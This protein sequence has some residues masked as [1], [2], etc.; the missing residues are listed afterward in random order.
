MSLQ[1]DSEMLVN[2]ADNVF[3][4]FLDFYF[5][6]GDL[7]GPQP[8]IKEPCAAYELQVEHHGCRI[9]CHASPLVMRTVFTATTQCGRACSQEHNQWCAGGFLWHYHLNHCGV[10]RHLRENIP[11]KRPEL[12]CN[13][14]WA[15]QQNNASTQSTL[16]I[17]KLL[18][19]NNTVNT[20]HWF[21][22]CGHRLKFTVRGQ[23]ANAHEQCVTK[24]FIKQMLMMIKWC[25]LEYLLMKVTACTC[26]MHVTVQW[27]IRVQKKQ[28]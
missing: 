19:T 20:P 27:P 13:G 21:L 18:A 10:L 23:T 1:K 22:V 24:M 4:R 9:S 3:Q 8:A 7:K 15:L 6:K 11:H 5:F 12:C 16:E 17:C 25:N 2:S 28:G 26:C 14:I